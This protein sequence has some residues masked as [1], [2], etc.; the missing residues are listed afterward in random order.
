[1]TT[2]SVRRFDPFSSL[3]PK[4][5]K[6]S[7]KLEDLHEKPVSAT[8]SLQEGLLIMISKLIKMTE[9]LSRCIH[10]VSDLEFNDCYILAK[11]AHMLEKTLTKQILESGVTSDQL[12]T[13]LRFPLRLERI[14]D[15]L[16]SVLNCCRIRS[17]DNLPLSDCAH[18]E[19][20]RLFASVIEMMIGAR[21]AFI[22]VDR[23]AVEKI[24]S[25]SKELGRMVADSRLAHWDRVE[26]GVCA[27]QASSLYLDILDS[28]ETVKRYLERICVSLLELETKVLVVPGAN[29]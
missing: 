13:L 10:S 17:E 27:Y 29:G 26:T 12:E 22:E 21:D 16:E 15:M 14:G 25:E 5:D 28:L 8:V 6:A 23:H 9:M 2:N 7:L 18:E 24:L 1:M 20:D 3:T 19:L 4:L 11:E